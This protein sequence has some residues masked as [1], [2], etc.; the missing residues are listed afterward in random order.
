M[1]K[2]KALEGQTFL[3]LAMKEAGSPAAAF[4]MAEK[5]NRS[6]T[7]ELASGTEVEASEVVEKPVRQY[8]K[9]NGLEPATGDFP[10]NDFETER[11]FGLEF[12]AEFA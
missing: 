11:V 3:D 10:G 6:V 1:D 12:P 5:N 9:D 2:V 7:D 4:A 8:Y